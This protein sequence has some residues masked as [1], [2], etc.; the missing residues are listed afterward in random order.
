MIMD[1]M[2]RLL[3]VLAI[4]APISACGSTSGVFTAQRDDPAATVTPRPVVAPTLKPVPA[5][6]SPSSSAIPTPRAALVPNPVYGVD[7][8]THVLSGRNSEDPVPD[9]EIRKLLTVLQGKTQWVRFYNVMTPPQHS[10]RI[11][12][13]MGFKVAAGITLQASS[14]EYN[15]QSIAKLVEDV[16]NGYVDYALAGSEEV[17]INALTPEQEIGYIQEVKQKVRGKVPVGTVE[18]HTVFLQHP[19][20]MRACDVVLANIAPISYAV[21]LGQSLDYIK[22]NYAKL[23]SLAGGVEVGI[24]ETNWPSSGFGGSVAQE[25][26]YVSDFEAWARAKQLRA[27]YF[28]AF[29]EPYLAQ[30]NE[31]GAHWGLWTSDLKLKAGLEWVFTK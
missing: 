13:E 27:F 14:P 8:G 23:V 18:P 7:V 17:I 11:A 26:K 1:G 21:P 9:G 16:N 19:E 29:D 4:V 2:P 12:H 15:E 3:A 31:V 5:S 24:G 20:I 22:T 6:S 25:A 10:T 30:Y 28:E